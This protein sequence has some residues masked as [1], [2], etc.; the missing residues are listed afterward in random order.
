MTDLDETEYTAGNN[1]LLHSLF[2]QCSISLNGSQI[3]QA[4]EHCGFRAYLE[5]LLTYGNDAAES[6]LRMAY[7]ELD[8]GDFKA[9]DCSKPA[10]LFN[11]SFCARCNHVKKSQEVQ[12]YGRLHADI[13]NVPQLLIT[14]LK[15][16]INL[17]K[18]KPELY[19]LSSKENGKVYFKILEALSYVK[20]FRPTSSIL[21]SH[22]EALL[23]GYPIRYNI[24]RIEIKTYIFCWF[25]ITLH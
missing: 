16:L 25:T 15:V 22:N 13:C 10:E 24:T 6:H 20:R 2:S 17:T 1:N 18:A 14:G 9:G 12:M 8:E 21:T 3:T 5:S 11:T 4:S 19:F 23:A 7:W